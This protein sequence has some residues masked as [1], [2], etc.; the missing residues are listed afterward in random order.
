MV[1]P[2]HWRIQLHLQKRRGCLCNPP[3]NVLAGILA[4]LLLHQSAPNDYQLQNNVCLINLNTHPTPKVMLHFHWF[5]CSVCK[6]ETLDKIS[7]SP[8][9]QKMWTRQWKNILVLLVTTL[10]LFGVFLA[11][12]VPKYQPELY[13]PPDFKSHKSMTSGQW[14]QFIHF[15]ERQYKDRRLQLKHFCHNVISKS[16]PLRPLM[17]HPNPNAMIYDK[18][19]KLAYCQIPKVHT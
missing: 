10:I 11:T 17:V 13:I 6:Q 5:W 4:L 12:D 9:V 2:D 18:K 19:H 7:L 14:I 3:W 15:K 16:H 1:F 8:S